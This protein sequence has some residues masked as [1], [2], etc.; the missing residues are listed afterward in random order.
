VWDLDGTL[1]DSAPDLA[2]ALN[3]LLRE[4]GQPALDTAAVR[5]M[6]GDGAV[7]LIERG[8]AAAGH[9][10]AARQSVP[11]LD[12][13]LQIYATC[14]TDRTVLYAGARTALQA[15]QD[16]GVGQGICTNKP[17]G[18]T[19]QILNSLSIAPYF[20]A[21]VGGDTAA[22]KKPDPSPLRDCL[23][24]LGAAPADGLLIGDSGVDVAT[25]RAVP[26]PVGIVTHG[27]ARA[28]VANLG[29]DFLIDCLS[30]LPGDVLAGR[31][32]AAAPA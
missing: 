24:E 23:R 30:S 5:S 19:R 21:V 11:L 26:M 15:F 25:A 10:M 12:R 18:V 27:Y 2:S 7:K 29:A 16:A 13:F 28:P 1:I 14:A 17:E 9:A 6:I 20:S 31:L 8:F 32:T 3:L 4:H 22:A